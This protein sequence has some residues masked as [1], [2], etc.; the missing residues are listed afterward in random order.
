MSDRLGLGVMINMLGGTGIDETIQAVK[1]SLGKTIKEIRKDSIS[2]DS[3]LTITFEDGSKLNLWDGGRSCCESRYLT[4][5]DNLSL[6][7]GAEFRD[8]EMVELPSIPQEYGDSHD[9][10]ALNI[11]TSK[12]IVQCVT[13]NEHNGYYGGFWIQAKLEKPMVQ[14]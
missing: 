4:C 5:E 11:H 12:G 8:V 7:V 6:F 9:C 1:D 10:Q 14:S 2:E 3:S 13:H